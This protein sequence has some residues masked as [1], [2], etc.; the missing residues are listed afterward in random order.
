MSLVCSP[1]A[2]LLV[3]GLTTVN[4]TPSAAGVK[5]GK[6]HFPPGPSGPSAGWGAGVG[7]DSA[8]PQ[9]KARPHPV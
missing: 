7:V 4:T 3:P 6:A 8:A 5:A 2:T 1:Q 9:A